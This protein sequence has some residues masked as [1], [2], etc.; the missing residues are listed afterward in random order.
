[1]SGILIIIYSIICRWRKFSGK[2][3]R[4]PNY[5]LITQILYVQF[6]L[7]EKKLHS[8]FIYTQFGWVWLNA[9][10]SGTTGLHLKKS[11][12]YI[13]RRQS[14]GKKLVTYIT[15]NILVAVH[16]L[17]NFTMVSRE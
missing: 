13:P 6:E 7:S 11:K 17:S 1:M 12:F 9:L 3:P 4:F 10:I 14:R 5:F 2:T 8:F 16:F 15:I